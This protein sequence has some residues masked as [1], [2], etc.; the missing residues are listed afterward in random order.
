LQEAARLLS[1]IAL[2]SA[3][4]LGLI[5]ALGFFRWFLLMGREVGSTNTWACGFSAPTPRLQY[6]GSSLVQPVTN[7]LAM[8]LPMRTNLERPQGYFPQ[9]ASLSTE[10]FDF[11]QERLYK[12]V[13]MFVGWTLSKLRWLQHGLTHF[14]VL[15]IAVTVVVLLIWFLA[16]RA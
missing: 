8:L 14:Y 16:M 4:L 12:P 13:F 11:W 9:S 10:T 6:T 1:H 3:V 15:Y 2:L 7:L 5:G